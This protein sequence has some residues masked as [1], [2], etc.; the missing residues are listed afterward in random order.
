MTHG[1]SQLLIYGYLSFTAIVIGV[2]V[3]LP[4]SRKGR[5]LAGVAAA[6]VMSIPIILVLRE[7]GERKAAV[8]QERVQVN[9]AQQRFNELCGAENIKIFK[10]VENVETISL[11]KVRP[12]LDWKDY[13]DP[14]LP[15]AA[16][17]T[18]GSG[19]SYIASFLGGERAPMFDIPP[20]MSPE[21]AQALRASVRG[22]IGIEPDSKLPRYRSVIAPDPIDGKIYKFS[23]AR[24]INS[25]VPAGDWERSRLVR[26]P[27]AGLTADYGVD[28]EDIVE[29]SD[30][31]MW[32]AGTKVRVL[33]I[34]TGA[35]LGEMTRYVRDGGMGS[36][37]GARAPWQHAGSSALICPNSKGM[38]DT[39]SRYFVDQVLKPKKGD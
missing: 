8:G 36:S 7:Y 15:G 27:V 35:I 37:G 30:R 4:R 20:G 23:A 34:R 3:W 2:A 28:Y 9:A 1:F 25:A 32:I 18:E 14:M 12:K 26:E 31:K 22:Q 16:M 13:F 21:A 24:T 38:A 33:D 29:P 11:L 17:A 19:Y 6:G 39:T 10:V 5:A